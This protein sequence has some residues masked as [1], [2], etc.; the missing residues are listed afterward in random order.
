MARKKSSRPGVAEVGDLQE[1]AFLRAILDGLDDDTPR[2]VYADW[3]EER[4]NPWGEFIRCQCLAAQKQTPA[5]RKKEYTARA[6]ELMAQH[7]WLPLYFDRTATEVERG[8]VTR[9]RLNWEPEPDDATLAPYASDPFF[10]LTAHY[11]GCYE[12]PQDFAIPVRLPRLG[13]LGKLDWSGSWLGCV[14]EPDGLDPDAPESPM[15]VLLLSSPHLVGLR[16]LRLLECGLKNRAMLALAGNPALASLRVLAA[17]GFFDDR[18]VKALAQSPHLAGLEELDLSRSWMSDRGL[19][20]LCES[21]HLTYLRR[22]G[23]GGVSLTDRGYQTL[24]R[25]PFAARLKELRVGKGPYQDCREAPGDVG[26]RALAESPHLGQIE[27]LH[28]ELRGL[29]PDVVQALRGR[30]GDRVKVRD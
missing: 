15:A 13:C 12:E 21:P 2:L 10:A 7:R 5:G 19:R 1:D 11:V 24:A 6:G 9:Y 22:L 4:G 30:F 20:H 26:A 17:G 16:E 14:A 28:V 27:A 18:A 3:L 29:S 25:A 23:L 8:F